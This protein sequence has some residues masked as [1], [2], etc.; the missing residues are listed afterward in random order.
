MSARS[1]LCGTAAHFLPYHWIYRT[2]VYGI[3][4]V[5]VSLGAFLVAMF[6]KGRAIYF[7]GFVV[8]VSLL[9]GAFAVRAH[10]RATW[11]RR[12]ER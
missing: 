8:G 4:G 11:Q 9:V 10:A 2:K 12:S 7:T 3:L 1:T 6:S 5:V